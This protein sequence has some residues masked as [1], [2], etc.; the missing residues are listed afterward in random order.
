METFVEIPDGVKADVKDKHIVISGPGGT[1]EKD[2]DDPRFNHLLDIKTDGKKITVAASG[3]RRKLGS[4]AGAIAAHTRNMVIG[5][6]KGYKYEMKIFFTHFPITVTAT[7]DEVQ[8]KNFLGEKGARTAK[9]AKGAEVHVDKE[10]IEIRGA[11]VEAVGQ[12]AANIELACKIKG[13]DRRIFQDGIYLN[14]RFTKTGEK[15]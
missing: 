13:R 15:L 3:E 4:L 12:T 14:G 6:T 8:I 10:H 7:K 2:F 9:V 1:L 5:V 11:D